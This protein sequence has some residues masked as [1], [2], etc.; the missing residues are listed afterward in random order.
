MQLNIISLV[1]K[2]VNNYF[3]VFY[4]LAVGNAVATLTDVKKRK[5][6]DMVGTKNSTSD[7]VHRNYNQR[8]ECKLKFNDKIPL[9]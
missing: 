2:Q 5:R 8:F 1:F 4:N 6:Y 7:H 3:F 9:G